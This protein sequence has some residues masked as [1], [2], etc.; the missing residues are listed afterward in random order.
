M[1]PVVQ[2]AGGCYSE[3]YGRVPVL[4][5]FLGTGRIAVILPA[6]VELMVVAPVVV[7]G[8]GRQMKVTLYPTAGS[9]FD[10]REFTDVEKIDQMNDVV[11]VNGIVHTDVASVVVEAED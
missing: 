11:R 4:R 6:L 3:W 2:Y 5:V 1:V 9:H 7:N 10:V 8:G